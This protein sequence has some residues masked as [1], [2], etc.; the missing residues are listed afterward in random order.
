MLATIADRIQLPHKARALYSDRR[1]VVGSIP[2]A[3]N[4]VDRIVCTLGTTLTELGHSQ[5]DVGLT[6]NW[7]SARRTIR[8]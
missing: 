1:E 4:S 8:V 5:V 6:S 3:C 7:R 2:V